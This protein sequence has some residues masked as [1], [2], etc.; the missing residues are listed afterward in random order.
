MKNAIA[1]LLIG[2]AMTALASAADT[3]KQQFQKI[4]DDYLDQVYFPYNPS[5][6]TLVG[7]HQYDTQ[8]EDLSRKTIDA[9]I[10]ALKSYDTRVSAIPAAG[11]D[12]TT[13]GDRDMV[14]SNIH[15]TLLALE[16]VRAWEKNPLSDRPRET[17]AL[18]PRTGP[19]QSQ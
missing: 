8:L 9:Q 5:T 2:A 12:Q 19:R 14:L 7:Y 10:A 15:S 6:G 1:L 17:H 4:S 16:T 18:P 11:L 13:R 3:A